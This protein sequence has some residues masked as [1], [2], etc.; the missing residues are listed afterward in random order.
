MALPNTFVEMK[1]INTKL[2]ENS[3][4]P[5]FPNPFFKEE[6]QAYTSCLPTVLLQRLQWRC[7]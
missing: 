4:P 6:I 2:K 3:A 5:P 1:D 7:Y